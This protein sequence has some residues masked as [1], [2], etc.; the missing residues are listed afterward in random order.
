MAVDHVGPES[1][2]GSPEF[3][4]STEEAAPAHRK[5]DSLVFHSHLGQPTEFAP[6]IAHHAHFASVPLLQTRSQAPDHF[7]NPAAPGVRRK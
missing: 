5:G 7:H 6:F 4:P 2:E 3:A 1:P